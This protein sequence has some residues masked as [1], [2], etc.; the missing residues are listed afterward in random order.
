[1][2]FIEKG[3]LAP[4]RGPEITKDPLATDKGCVK[5]MLNITVIRDASSTSSDIIVEGVDKDIKEKPE[6]NTMDKVPVSA[7]PIFLTE[8]VN[9]DK[10]PR[11]KLPERRW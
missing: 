8:T 6:G 5:G 11:T 9:D 2:I 1:M 7:A 4:I 3:I 10:V